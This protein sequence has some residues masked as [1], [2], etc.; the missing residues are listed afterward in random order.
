MVRQD[1]QREW[2]ASFLKVFLLKGISSGGDSF[3]PFNAYRRGVVESLACG[4]TG[5]PFLNHRFRE[6]SSTPPD[7]LEWKSVLSPRGQKGVLA[8][9]SQVDDSIRREIR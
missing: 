2:A 1:V 6:G 8:R 5:R 7:K 9:R 4:R 3:F